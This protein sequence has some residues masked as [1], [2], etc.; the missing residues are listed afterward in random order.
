MQDGL[1]INDTW[2]SETEGMLLT[3]QGNDLQKPDS[4]Q[5]SF[6]RE[7]SLPDSLAV[8][9]LTQGGEGP[10]SSSRKPYQHLPAYLVA[11][12]DRLFSGL[13]RLKDFSAGWKV[14]LFEK[15][16]YLFE[17]LDRSI[18]TAD[19]ARYNFSWNLDYIGLQANSREGVVFPVIDYGT[20][21]NGSLPVDNMYP[22]MY[23]HTLVEQL[24]SEEGYRLSGSLPIDGLYNR[25]ILP[26]VEAEPV[27]RDEAWIEARK[28]RVTGEDLPPVPFIGGL[29]SHKT[30]IEFIE[31][32][33]VDNDPAAG[34]Y[35]NGVKN[36]KPV[37]YSY[38]CDAPMRLIIEAVQWF[39]VSVDIGAVEAYLTIEKNGQAIESGYF[40]ESGVYNQT[41]ATLDKVEVKAKIDCQPG[42]QIRVRF[43]LGRQ[44]ATAQYRGILIRDQQNFAS[45]VPDKVTAYGDEWN[46]ARNLPD[47]TALS[48][49]KAIAFLCSGTYYV[50]ELRKQVQFIGFSDI[51]SNLANAVDWSTRVDESSEPTYTPS[52][53]PYARKNYLKWKPGDGIET[54]YGDGMLPCS[55]DVLPESVDLFELPFSATTPSTNTIGFYG[56]PVRIETRS[57]ATDTDG[58]TTVSSKAATPRLLLAYPETSIT[59]PTKRVNEKGEVVEASAFLMPCWFDKRPGVA[60]NPSVNYSLN[61]ESYTGLIAR[62]YTGLK[63]VLRRPR[64]LT[65]S[66][67]LEV[68][69]IS[70]LDLSLPVRLQQVRVGSIY[71]NDGYWYINRISNYRP[72]R[73]CNV[74]L[75]AIS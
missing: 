55:Y 16:R 20:L 49:L 64:K 51:V 67:Q 14:E 26:F 40:N 32:F 52:L 29:L 59:V 53:E 73:P 38:V 46:V 21:K 6:T 28:A 17:R 71:L 1:Y 4:L 5:S 50:N 43:K 69:D 39:K 8:R 61:F 2:V 22:A 13:A 7:Y 9:D 11:S 68:A 19:L 36:Y 70:G 3:L 27:S 62:Y 12:G 24:L 56:E 25:L 60:A 54:G 15:K 34:W 58:K 47:I 45:F 63:R 10:D 31:P 57:Y 30:L 33:G 44:T 37:I 74:E 48:L 65:I 66:L 75:I 18:R 35:N 41:G 23:A 72:G 42:D